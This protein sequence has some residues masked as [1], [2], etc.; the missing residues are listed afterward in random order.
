[1]LED[2]AASTFGF[3]VVAWIMA[4]GDSALLLE[5]GKFVFT[6]PRNF[7]PKLKSSS[8]PFTLKNKELIFSIYSVPFRLFIVSDISASSGGPRD[9]FKMLSTTFR[10]ERR[11][12]SLV[13][14]A[15]VAMLLLIAGPMMSASR[16]VQ[17][18]IIMLL[19]SLYALGIAASAIIWS[20]RKSFGLSNGT[21]LKISAELV[22]CPVCVVNVLKRISLAQSWQ[23]NTVSVAH[24]CSS[25]K[26]ALHAVSENLQF[27]GEQVH[28][29]GLD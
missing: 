21:A 23:P 19:P 18:S 16:G 24:F 1:M 22:L 3:W 15:L 7:H 12:R 10:R 25:P 4:F 28:G 14:V 27:H 20:H 2:L 17:F 13:V 5:P 6:V 29:F 9:T 11:A 26:E 8:V